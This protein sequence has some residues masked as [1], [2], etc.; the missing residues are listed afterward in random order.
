MR[1]ATQWA[2]TPCMRLTS[3]APAA[4]TAA[5]AVKTAARAA[6]VVK[7]AAL[8]P[9]GGEGASAP[10]RPPPVPVTAGSGLEARV[11]RDLGV[12]EARDRAAFLGVAG[13]FLERGFGRAGDAGG[14]FEVDVRHGEAGVGLVQRH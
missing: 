2:S 4:T 5:C 6:G 1:Q 10:L 8:P 13:G 3:A 7:A 12:Q 14:D 11:H 9:R